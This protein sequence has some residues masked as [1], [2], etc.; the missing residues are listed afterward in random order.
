MISWNLR[1]DI[2]VILF[3]KV[4]HMTLSFIYFTGNTRNSFQTKKRFLSYRII[5]YIC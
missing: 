2:D 1:V 4:K 3:F 5:P